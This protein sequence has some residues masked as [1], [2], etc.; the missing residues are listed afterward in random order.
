MTLCLIPQLSW[1][2][3]HNNPF[4]YVQASVITSERVYAVRD[5]S[6]RRHQSE[7]SQLRPAMPF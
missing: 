2:H 7:S 4:S 5:S 3:I 1:P 6:R